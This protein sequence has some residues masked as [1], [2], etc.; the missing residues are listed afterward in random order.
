MSRVTIPWRV[1]RDKRV[2]AGWMAT[3]GAFERGA[4]NSCGVHVANE[5][6]G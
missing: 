4:E 2:S 3:D 6:V 1:N 5:S